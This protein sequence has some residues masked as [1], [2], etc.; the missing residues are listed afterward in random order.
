M[1]D[2]FNDRGAWQQRLIWALFYHMFPG[3]KLEEVAKRLGL[4]RDG[5]PIAEAIETGLDMLPEGGHNIPEND[6]A[7]A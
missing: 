2:G 7:H 6:P 5:R 1:E 4:G 3:Q